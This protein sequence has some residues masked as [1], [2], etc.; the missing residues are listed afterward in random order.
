[1]SWSM[2]P[3]NYTCHTNGLIGWILKQIL[4]EVHANTDNDRRKDG[5]FPIYA[6]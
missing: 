4:E 3:V 5:H 1:M 6:L 2:L